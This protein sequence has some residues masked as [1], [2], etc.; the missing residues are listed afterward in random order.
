M[1][2]KISNLSVPYNVQMAHWH[3]VKKCSKAIVMSALS[4]FFGTQFTKVLI[5]KTF[6]VYFQFSVS[7]F[8]KQI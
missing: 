7:Q 1:L 6:F 8:T 4:L 5:I 3:T 2:Y